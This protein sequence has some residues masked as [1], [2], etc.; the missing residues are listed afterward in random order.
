MTQLASIATGKGL[1]RAGLLRM[2]IAE[3]IQRVKAASHA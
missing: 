3:Y 2:L 1:S